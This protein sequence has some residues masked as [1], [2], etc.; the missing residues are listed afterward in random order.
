MSAAFSGHPQKIT[1]N[2]YRLIVSEK[3]VISPVSTEARARA[4]CCVGTQSKTFDVSVQSPYNIYVIICYNIYVSST[5]QWRAGVILSCAMG[6]FTKASWKTGTPETSWKMIGMFNVRDC[7]G[8]SHNGYLGF[9]RVVSDYIKP[10]E[11]DAAKK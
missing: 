5:Q 10:F 11:H 7:G 1:S 2:N 6:W 8:G 4:C 9:Q 3:Y